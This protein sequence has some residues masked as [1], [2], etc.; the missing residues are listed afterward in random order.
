MN[1]LI[2]YIFGSLNNSERQVKSVYNNQIQMNRINN[3]LIFSGFITSV[4]LLLVSCEL[5]K[6]GKEIRR[7][8]IEIEELKNQKGD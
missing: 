3:R 1:E 5:V 7:M 6:Q 2:D 4:T 8:K